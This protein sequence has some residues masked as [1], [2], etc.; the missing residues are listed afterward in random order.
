[1]RTS[2]QQDLE[3]REQVRRLAAWLPALDN[4][5]QSS[6]LVEMARSLFGFEDDQIGSHNWELLY[7]AA[8]KALARPNWSA[9]VLRRSRLEA[10]FLTNDFDDPLTGFDTRVYV[11]CLR[12]DE[13]VF[14]LARPAVRQRLEAASGLAI[15]DAGS[16][17]AALGKLFEHFVSHGARACAISLPPSFAPAKVSAAAAGRAVDDSLAAGRGGRSRAARRRW[18]TSCSGRW[19]S[20]APRSSC[21]SI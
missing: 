5:I 20:T 17:A 2:K 9:E 16:L 3:P 21:R 19:P 7:D 10:V 4:T 15:G 6:W 12:T 11:P 14:H 18:Q 8:E 13:L 1:M